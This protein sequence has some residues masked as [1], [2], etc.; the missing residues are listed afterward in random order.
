MRFIKDMFRKEND[1]DKFAR[2]SLKALKARGWKNETEYDREKFEF[3][4]CA[5]DNELKV[6]YLVNTYREWLKAPPAQQQNII[7]HFVDFIIEADTGQPIGDDAL[8]RL[9]PILRSRV[10]SLAAFSQLDGAAHCSR[11]IRPFCENM[12]LM[13]A[14]DLDHG[15][16]HL[17]DSQMDE[18]GVS[19]EDCLGAAT[20]NLLDVGNHK[21][22]EIEPGVFVSNCDDM[23]DASRILLHNIIG[24]L[25]VKG[26]PVAIP[27]SRSCVL[28]TGSE[29]KHGLARITE[30]ALETLPDEDRAISAAPI[31]LVEGQW[32]PFSVTT[33]HFPQ[34][35]RL[36]NYQ[37][38]WNYS[39]D[40]DSL[41][42]RIGEDIY[43][44]S[45][46]TIE[47][48]NQS[49]SFATWAY[50]VP[51]IIPK[52]N[53]IIVETDDQHSRIT[54]KFEDVNLVCGP[55][56]LFDETEFPVR[57]RL[58]DIIS[59]DQLT[60]LQNQFPEYEFFES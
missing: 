19:F 41:Q 49:D 31:E 59:A 43:V 4:H 5:R 37:R 20:T 14:I 45:F 24:Q 51:T 9:L 39:S 56:D 42:E 40:K 29:D 54:R 38:L 23:Y 27:L 16:A 34:I 26:N 7:E 50:G 36:L 12:L 3:K 6:T 25:P 47:N 30:I 48:A 2:I 8:A 13:L 11:T 58:P 22:S 33:D 52:V 32:R 57:Y 35:N 1:Q 55:L 21:F 46:C 15:I 17:T 53:A 28:L 18:L 60:R 10:D 44:A